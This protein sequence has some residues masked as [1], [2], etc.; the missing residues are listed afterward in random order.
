MTLLILLVSCGSTVVERCNVRIV[1]NKCR[2]HDYQVE[3]KNPRR[4]SESVD[5]PLA[6]CDNH[7]SLSPSD[8]GELLKILQDVSKGEDKEKAQSLIH[9]FSEFSGSEDSL[10]MPQEILLR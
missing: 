2:C 10:D 8:W 3:R 7:V 1:D 4:I 5:Y 9:E 6:Y